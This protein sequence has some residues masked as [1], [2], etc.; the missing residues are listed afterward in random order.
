MNPIIGIRYKCSILPDFDYCEK[1]EEKN[2]KEHKHPMIKIREANHNFVIENKFPVLDVF[3]DE[4]PLGKSPMR[5]YEKKEEK[6]T[7]KKETNN[8]FMKFFN[9]IKSKFEDNKNPKEKKELKVI[10]KDELKTK[11][12]L[13]KEILKENKF[14]SEEI[15]SALIVTKLDLNKAIILLME[16]K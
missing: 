2:W 6:N 1:C 8:I 5:K 16:M 13:I 10:D 3:L 14:T 15:K 12:K 11:K 9:D 7:C 4:I